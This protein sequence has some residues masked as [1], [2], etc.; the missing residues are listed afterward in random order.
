MLDIVDG[1]TK[2]E[3]WKAEAENMSLGRADR[4]CA[5]RHHHSVQGNSEQSQQEETEIGCTS[6]LF[7]RGTFAFDPEVIHY[8]VFGWLRMAGACCPVLRLIAAIF[9]VR[10]KALERTVFGI[11]LE[12]PVGLAA[13]LDKDARV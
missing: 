4:A 5:G 2:K 8:R 7:V 6:R 10:H 1:A 11:R 13:G 3:L 9:R 12:N